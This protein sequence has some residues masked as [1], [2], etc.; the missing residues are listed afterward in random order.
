MK[1][2]FSLAF[3]AVVS[4][5]GLFLGDLL[6]ASDL[7]IGLVAAIFSILAAALFAVI[8]IIGDPSMLLKGSKTVAWVSGQQLYKKIV[9]YNVLFFGYLFTLGL[10]VAAE[11]AQTAHFE[12][13]YFLYSLIGYLGM[14]CFICS[15]FLSFRLAALQKT[16]LEEA[17]GER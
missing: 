4:I 5:S 17:I 7:A 13:A 2:Y 6:R 15:L 1:F 3:A 14:L 9:W 8:T 10:L 12:E 11:L 16:R